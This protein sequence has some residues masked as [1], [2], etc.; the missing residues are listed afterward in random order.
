MS[1]R[2]FSTVVFDLGA[3]VLGWDPVPAFA[4]VLPAEDVPAFLDK[5][6]FRT[7]NHTQDAGRPFEAGEALLVE[8]HGAEHTEAI[9]AYRLHFPKTLTGMIPGTGAVIAELQRAGVRLLALTNW[10][11]ETFPHARRRFGLLNRFEDILVSGAERLAKPDPAIFRLLIERYGLEAGRTVFVDDVAANIAGSEEV[12]LTGIQ[13]TDAAALRA[14]LVELGLLGPW[15]PVPGP[16]Y[17][18]TDA[19]TWQAARAAGEFPWSTRDVPYDSE[20]YVHLSFAGQ[21]EGVRKH[22]YPEHADADLVLLRLDPEP[23]DPIVAED[24]G[25]GEP[26]PHLYAQLPLERVRP[27]PLSG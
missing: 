8:Q 7:W 16:V 27:E 2:S 19:E 9:Q 13:F 4:T 10:S 3:V 17:H 26:Y 24:L 23:G 11:H 1:E 21:V 12:G 20:G 6:D 25:A 5:I 14:R 15:Q 22:L 18:L